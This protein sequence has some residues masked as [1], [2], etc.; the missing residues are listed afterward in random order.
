MFVW[1]CVVLIIDLLRLSIMSLFSL[2]LFDGASQHVGDVVDDVNMY[3][4]V[5]VFYFFLVTVHEDIDADYGP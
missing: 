1:L 5:R 4:W 2:R 3:D